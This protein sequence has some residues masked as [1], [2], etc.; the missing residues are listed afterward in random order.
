M[1]DGEKKLA[2]AEKDYE[3]G[4]RKGESQIKKAKADI[5]KGEKELQDNK[6]KLDA[7]QKEIDKGETRLNETK[8]LLDDSKKQ[9]NDSKN[10]LDQL[11]QQMDGLAAAIGQLPPEDPDLPQMNAQYETLSQTYDSGMLQ[12]EEGKKQY[13]G[14]FAQYKEGKA[15]FDKRKAEFEEG[16]KLYEQGVKA[17]Q[18]GKAQ[19]KEAERKL[20]VG[21]R[22]GKKKIE[23]AKVELEDGKKEL[24]DNEKEFEDK[25][26]ESQQEIDDAQK[27]ID[28]AQEQIDN[29][30]EAKWYVLGRKKIESFNNYYNDSNR[31]GNIGKV[32]PIIFFLVAALVSLTTM[33]RM[34]EEHR[35]Q[36]GLMKALGY[37]RVA[38]T[39]KYLG[40]AF[41]ASIIGSG[42][43]MIIGH[44]VL[45]RVIF[46]AYNMMYNLDDI[47]IRYY[48]GHSAAA[49]SAT[50]ASITVATYLACRKELN[51][52]SADLMR[53][54]PPVKGK[55]V[56][57]ERIGFIWRHL[58]FNRK[59]TIR[60]LMRYRLRF[61]MTVLGVVGCMSLLIMGFGLRD[62]IAQIIGKQFGE[63]INYDIEMT[64][65]SGADEAKLN[66]LFGKVNN[67]ENF[68]S[69]M[70]FY[71]KVVN[72]DA[73]GEEMAARL[74]MP[75]NAKEIENYMSL[76]TRKGHKPLHIGDDGVVL[77]E[78]IGNVMKQGPGGNMQINTDD[79]LYKAKISALTEHYVWHYIYFS[80]DY[81][82]SIFG[83]V[84]KSNSILIKTTDITHEQKEAIAAEYLKIPEIS[85]VDVITNQNIKD[86]VDAM[87]VIIWVLVVSAGALALVVL[88]NLTNINISERTQELATIKVLGF[89]NPEVA[90]YIYRENII[91]TA[92]GIIFGCVLGHYLHSYIVITAEVSDV[93]FVRTV[94][95]L[96]YIYSCLITIGF[97]ALVNI[98]MSRH[99]RRINMVES[100]K[101][102]E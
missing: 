72:V 38:V 46:N 34:I 50:V 65:D 74:I 60:N 93:M 86:I 7:G 29:L 62:S 84:P 52:V 91:M 76:R 40:Y 26:I 49:A 67:D 8:K 53:P 22:E 66:D 71:S 87:D 64:Y 15:E 16:K 36:L 77:T 1:A 98:I 47:V 83:E 94:S 89:S 81:Y 79:R 97:A 9:L 45:P 75:E 17:L 25:K 69:T 101:S 56:F 63:I 57:L 31:V 32:F 35:T 70:K 27:E 30:K 43:G 54:K 4:I 13:D 99:M 42:I 61:V 21:K 5:N 90:M 85:A 2:D 55:R 59:I 23:E 6:K 102:G 58:G 19:V 24:A 80:P 10:Q 39:A 68:V 82:K 100:L 48:N 11:K 20:A 33:M 28:D 41:V 18:D 96:S 78:K 88:Y 14:G 51:T 95:Y 44:L 3:N 73:N 12:Y 92:I 37:S